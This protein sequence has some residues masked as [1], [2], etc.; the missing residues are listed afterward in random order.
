MLRCPFNNFSKCDGSCP[1]SE[2][3]FN[4]CLLATN[5]NMA[6]GRLMGLLNRADDLKK[7]VARIDSA[8][9]T[10]I[11]MLEGIEVVGEEKPAQRP[12]KV[13]PSMRDECYLYRNVKPDGA[14]DMRVSLNAE[15]AALVTEQ[16]G[17]KVDAALI[18]S[19]KT[20]VLLPGSSMTVSFMNRGGRAS[21]SIGGLRRR[22]EATFGTAHYTYLS[23]D[24]EDGMLKLRATGE[25]DE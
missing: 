12:K 7:D 15:V 4:S 3:N 10:I 2:D 11:G 18:D 21:V 22:L 6:A 24:F 1:F 16:L 17:E 20:L 25:V 8:L 14:V 19:T 13:T 5:G 23:A 9:T